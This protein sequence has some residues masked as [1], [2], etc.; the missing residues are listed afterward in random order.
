[1]RVEGAPVRGPKRRRYEDPEVVGERLDR[2]RC[3]DPE[4]VGERLD[5]HR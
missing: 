1:M 4:V 2:H 3:E 5:R